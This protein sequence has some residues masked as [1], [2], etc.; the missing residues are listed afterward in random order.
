M[1]CGLGRDIASAATSDSTTATTSAATWWIALVRRPSSLS[2]SL[3]VRVL[4][5]LVGRAGTGILSIG[6]LIAVAIAVDL[7]ARRETNL[8]LDDFIP[9]R[10]AA[11]TFRR[12]KQFAQALTKFVFWR[13]HLDLYEYSQW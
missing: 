1:R 7:V 13:I 12:G 3:F 11:F 2:L 5:T 9:L 6:N 4:A 10:I 8:Q